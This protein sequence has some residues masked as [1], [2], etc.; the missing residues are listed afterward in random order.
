MRALR[1]YAGPQARAHLQAHGL[2]PEHVRVVPAA[3]GGP[4]GL[5]L[6]PLDRFLFGDWLPRS[7]QPVDLVGASIGAWRMA[8]ACLDRPAEAF[9]RLEHDYIAQR[10]DLAQGQ[11]RPT[12][13]H[14]SER[15]A[16]NLKLF[17]GGR[18]HEVLQHPRYRLHVIA[19]RGRHMLAREH[20]LATPLGYLGAFVSNTVQRRAMGA[21]L[22]RVVFS[23]QSAAC[24]LAPATT[25]AAKW[26][27]RRPIS[28]MR[29]RP[30]APSPSCCA[31]SAPS[32]ARRQGPIG[33]A[34]SPTTTCTWTTA[35]P[36]RAWCCTR[37][38]SRPW[39]RAGW[40]RP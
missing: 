29:C 20:G 39:C 23:T 37:I 26:R 4:K 15:F 24:P 10:Y 5:V 22:E 34:A 40:T 31:R 12:A 27:S 32:P 19:S 38:F 1:L 6:G 21:W 9:G 35:A 18:E 17:F 25:A 30:V 7:R 11:K 13:E 2:L 14:V 3:A 16:D 33:M 36:P 8:T 28:W